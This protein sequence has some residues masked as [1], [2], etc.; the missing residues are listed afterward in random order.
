[1]EIRELL[2]LSINI[3]FKLFFRCFVYCGMIQ[4]KK[5]TTFLCSLD[6]TL[7]CLQSGK[8]TLE[9]IRF[10]RESTATF[11]NEKIKTSIKHAILKLL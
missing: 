6:L 11:L 8:I 1:M 7:S 9:I 4:I 5:R 10:R 3:M 2:Q